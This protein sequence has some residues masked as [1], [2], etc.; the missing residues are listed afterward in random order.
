VT[1]PGPHWTGL[2][3]EDTVFTI[4]LKKHKSARDEI[5][6][7]AFNPTSPERSLDPWR[8]SVWELE[9]S[10]PPDIVPRAGKET[11]N[12]AVFITVEKVRDVDEMDVVWDHLT[13]YPDLDDNFPGADGHSA[14]IGWPEGSSNTAS[15]ER[16]SI[17]ARLALNA[18]RAER[19][20][21]DQTAQEATE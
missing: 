8:K 1:K 7:M 12:V 6:P 19:I 9:L 5:S 21:P 10:S 13:K 16:R 14:I 17:R 11:R 18:H 2:D 3:D 15:K 4:D 20:S